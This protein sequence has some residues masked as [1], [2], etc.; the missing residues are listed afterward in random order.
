V[1][2]SPQSDEFL[3][4]ACDRGGTL[5]G[6]GL[7]GIAKGGQVNSPIATALAERHPLG[8]SFGNAEEA[9]A[10]VEECLAQRLNQRAV[11]GML[12]FAREAI[13][14]TLLALLRKAGLPE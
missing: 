7:P 13:R 3:A 4:P 2:R 6:G 10:A 8:A 1:A 5:R 9:R 14:E 12:R 11:P